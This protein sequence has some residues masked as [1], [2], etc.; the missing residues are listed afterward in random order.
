MIAYTWTIVSAVG[1]AIAALCAIIALFQAH[2][3]NVR[4]KKALQKA[5]QYEDIADTPSFIMSRCNLP[6]SMLGGVFVEFQL[7]PTIVN[8]GESLQVN[9]INVFIAEIP[10]KRVIG[11]NHY[12]LNGEKIQFDCSFQGQELAQILDIVERNQECSFELKIRPLA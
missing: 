7:I 8:A 4:S 6:T 1:S 12:V 10:L 3:S 2:S 11:S 9:E 5:E